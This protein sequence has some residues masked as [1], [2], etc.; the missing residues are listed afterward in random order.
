M[1]SKLLISFAIFI[2]S[3]VYCFAQTRLSVT[4]D[5]SLQRALNKQQRY[6]AFGQTIG[7][8]LG[9]SAKDAAYF[10]F[11]YYS[12]GKVSTALE[13]VAKSPAT[14]PERIAYTNQA[15]IGLRQMSVGWRHYLKGNFASEEWSIYS[16]LGFG[17]LFGTANNSLTMPVDSSLYNLAV[18]P[19]KGRFKRLTYDL[20]LGFEQPMG[21]DIFF[22]GELKTFIPSTD[23]PSQ[24]L[25]VSDD[26]PLSAYFNLGFRIL[27]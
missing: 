26:A 14:T 16:L 17:L 10:S 15:K 6:W 23:Y 1:K 3:S 21:G 5:F 20:G 11:A 18:M 27:F 19:G 8:Q 24:Y 25:Y 7:L 9:L 13:A 22:Y 2:L 4:S 12:N